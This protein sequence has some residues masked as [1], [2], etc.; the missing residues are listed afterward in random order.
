MKNEKETSRSRRHPRLY[1]NPANM[2]RSTT[3]VAVVHEV[4]SKSKFAKHAVFSANLPSLQSSP[5]VT[6]LLGISRAP[7]SLVRG[8]A[9]KMYAL[10]RINQSPTFFF[11]L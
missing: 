1:T 9:Q 6:T 4:T 8:R 5:A 2:A 3:H 11:C 10:P 7:T